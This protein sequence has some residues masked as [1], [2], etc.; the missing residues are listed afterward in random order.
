LAY[1]QEFDIVE[2]RT[3]QELRDAARKGYEKFDE[4]NGVHFHRKPKTD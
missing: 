2:V 3:P 1:V 4:M